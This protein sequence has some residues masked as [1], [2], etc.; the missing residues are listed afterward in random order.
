MKTPVPRLTRLLA[1]TDV[2]ERLGLSPKTVR[3]FIASQQLPVHRLGRALRV[4]E[5]DLAA[6][7]DR[8]RT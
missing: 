7:V 3:R 8:R 6:F 4:S 1:V 5:E 2:A